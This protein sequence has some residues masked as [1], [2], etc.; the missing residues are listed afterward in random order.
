MSLLD[1]GREDIIVYLEETVT[2]IDGNIRTR[3][4]VTGIPAKA[5]IQIKG[6]SGTSAR[7]SEQDNEGYESEEVYRMRLPRSFPHLIGAQSQIEWNGQRWAVFGNP[8][9]YNGSPRTAHIDY[10]IKR[11]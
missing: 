3:P 8:Q 7:R 9:V 5:T 2:D 4:S 6:Q 11:F 1:R 10:T